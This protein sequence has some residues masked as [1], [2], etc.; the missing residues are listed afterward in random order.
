VARVR[1]QPHPRCAAEGLRGGAGVSFHPPPLETHAH[2]PPGVVTPPQLDPCGRPSVPSPLLHLTDDACVCVWE[3]EQGESTVRSLTHN[4]PRMTHSRAGRVYYER[5]ATVHG[6]RPNAHS[7]EAVAPLRNTVAPA[8]MFHLLDK[9]RMA[10][11][12]AIDHV[13]ARPATLSA[14]CRRCVRVCQH[15]AVA[16][17]QCVVASWLLRQVC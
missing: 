16:G 2:T 11:T 7:E 6:G 10:H 15:D 3:R 14:V 9:V 8:V 13:C 4:A 12:Q 17:V 5:P 1:L